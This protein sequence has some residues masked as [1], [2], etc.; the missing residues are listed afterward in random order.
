[1]FF[2]CSSQWNPSFGGGGKTAEEWPLALDHSFK[3]TF[4]PPNFPR[5][6]IFAYTLRPTG[7]YYKKLKLQLP[8]ALKSL[9][10]YPDKITDAL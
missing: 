9:L 3:A 10:G 6:H 2:Y 5:L 1:M 7:F 8:F 4:T